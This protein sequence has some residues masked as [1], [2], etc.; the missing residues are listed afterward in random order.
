MREPSRATRGTTFRLMYRSRDQVPPEDR[1]D[2]LADL[3]ARARSNNQRRD[4]TG[5]LLVTGH[6]FVQVLEGEEAEVRSLFARIRS[7]ARHDGVELLSAGRAD[8]RIFVHWSMAR[9]AVDDSYIPLIAQISEVSP[10]ESGGSTPEK[11]RLLDVMRAAVDEPS[12]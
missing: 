12:S 11:S 7:D 1:A 2:E 10:A 3:F 4:I 5:A 6:W 9:V 8:E